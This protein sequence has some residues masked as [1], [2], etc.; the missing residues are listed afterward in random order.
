M[1]TW[2]EFA[3]EC[4]DIAENGLDLLFQHEVGLAYLA[5]VRADGGPRVHPISPLL[6]KHLLL[7]FI[8]PSPKRD[9]LLRNGLYSM[10]SFPTRDN[11][12]AFVLSG[13]AAVITDPVIVGAARDVYLTARRMPQ[14]P[15]DFDTE[16]LF[17]FRI[18]SALHT[19]T[20]GWADRS[21]EHTTW[22]LPA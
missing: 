17:E 22:R 1:L 16:K 7:A 12:D 18:E 13:R 19:K 10:H 4:P 6:A 11:D 15:P 21:P 3:D 9:D 2:R 8:I 14:A 5:T 20:K